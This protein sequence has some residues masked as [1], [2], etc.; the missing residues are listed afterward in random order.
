M[1][2]WEFAPLLLQALLTCPL[3]DAA[4]VVILPCAAGLRG[5]FE[6]DIQ[7][8]RLARRHVRPGRGTSALPSR[9][10]T[11]GVARHFARS[12]SK[13]ILPADMQQ[14]I[15]DVQPPG[16]LPKDRASSGDSWQDASTSSFALPTVRLI[17]ES[18]SDRVS[19]ASL[20]GRRVLRA[21]SM[22]RC[23]CR[24]ANVDCDTTDR[25]WAPMSAVRLIRSTAT[26]SR[27]E[28]DRHQH[29]SDMR[30]TGSGRRR[31]HIGDSLAV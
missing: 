15:R 30:W 24:R 9:R 3:L 10:S 31:N 6:D 4:A 23:V 7:C 28:P 21:D 17:G 2:E 5:Q 18:P 12:V 22:A 29:Y 14:A 8:P 25:R 26:G 19:I 20:R 1:R 27:C 11:R 16:I 13:R